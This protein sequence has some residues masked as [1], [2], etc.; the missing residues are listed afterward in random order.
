MRVVVLA[1]AMLS[2][3]SC[4]SLPKSISDGNLSSGIN[5]GSITIHCTRQLRNA[6]I[7]LN[8]SLVI[9][10]ESFKTIKIESVTPESYEIHI[11]SKQTWGRELHSEKFKI[12][13]VANRNTDIVVN[14]PSGTLTN[15]AY[16]S[17]IG[18]FASIPFLF[19]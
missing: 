12:T 8:D 11:V 4:A 15:V 5:K 9:N 18:L 17:F 3:A 13:V 2:I 6:F 1:V 10:G 14:A 19:S 16:L 7:T